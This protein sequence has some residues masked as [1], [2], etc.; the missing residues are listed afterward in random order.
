MTNYQTIIEAL[1]KY[2]EQLSIRWMS[3]VLLAGSALALQIYW[4]KW[5]CRSRLWYELRK[6]IPPALAAIFIAVGAWLAKQR[7]SCI[8]DAYISFRYARNLVE[9]HGLVFNIGERVEGYTNFLWTVL[10]ALLMKL[11]PYPAPWLSLV[12]DLLCYA[13]NLAVIYLIGQALSRHYGPRLYLPL[14]VIWLAVNQVFVSYATTGMETMLAGLWVSL[15]IYFLVTRDDARGAA[16]SGSMFILATFTRPDHAIFYV[17]AGLA[18]MSLNGR[19]ILNER[20]FGALQIWRSGGRRLAAYAA[21]FA[22]YLVY[23]IWKI[24]Y[25]G[26]IVP[27]TFYSRSVGQTYF[28]Q[29]FFYAAYFFLNAHFWVI[30]LLLIGWLLIRTDNPAAARMKVFAVPALILYNFYILSIGGDH[31]YGRFYV[32]IMPLMVLGAEDLIYFLVS[33][34]QPA[35]RWIAMTAV[36]LLAATI[37][38]T[39]APSFLMVPGETEKVNFSKPSVPFAPPLFPHGEFFGRIFTGRGIQPTLGTGG[40]GALGYYS[41]LPIVDVLGLTDATVSH[42]RITQR[43][44]PGHEKTATLDYLRQRRVN[45]VSREVIA[46]DRRFVDLR[47]M[48]FLFPKYYPF[49]LLIYDRRLMAEIKEKVPEARFTDF[50]QF[51]D[52]Y[53]SELPGKKPAEVRE[54]LDWFDKFYFDYNEDPARRK[55]IQAYLATNPAQAAVN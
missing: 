17:A 54:D 35:S 53:L 15:G 43:A 2:L 7:A 39:Q 18:L 45:L 31:L 55:A 25:Y 40:I 49:Y 48:T 24:N 26:D 28:S 11:T 6:I 4:H 3:I 9:G 44:K 38:G 29:G 52:R 14:A 36:C 47:E 5:G 1:D 21:P 51:L 42:Y 13:V 41:R 27:N 19:S 50:E 30:A 20:K 32:S 46:D 34:K 37:Y 33:Q 10:I 12:L 16:L 8:D 22:V 23:L